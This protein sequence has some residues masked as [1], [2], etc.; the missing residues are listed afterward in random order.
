MEKKN[1][2]Q[3]PLYYGLAFLLGSMGLVVSIVY[4]HDEL[5]EARLANKRIEQDVDALK[6]R[7]E[8]RELLTRKLE[9]L[10]SAVKE[11]VKI[12]PSAEIATEEELQRL[13]SRRARQ[14]GVRIEKLEVE[15]VKRK[16][17]RGRSR[18]A[19]KKA[20]AEPFSEVELRLV[21]EGGF[22]PFV[23]FLNT[24]EKDERFLKV[25][26]FQLGEPDERELIKAELRLSSFSYKVAG[27]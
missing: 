10:Q 12:L 22:V 19:R 16:P 14:A 24:L 23:S 9:E 20:E 15:P 26:F 4:A 6:A 17:I 11:Y 25:T 21:L 7:A 27:A 3:R 2:L 13:V 18:R 8:Q 1:A 5:G